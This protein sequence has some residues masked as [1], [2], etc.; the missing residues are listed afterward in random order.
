[1]QT[2][3]GSPLRTSSTVML[4]TLD[5]RVAQ[6]PR[7]VRRAMTRRLVLVLCLYE[8]NPGQSA[9]SIADWRHTPQG[10][11]KQRR[12]VNLDDQPG[13]EDDEMHTL[14]RISND[15]R[16]IMAIRRMPTMHKPS[17]LMKE[18]RLE[19]QREQMAGEVRTR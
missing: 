7:K 16:G 2:Q 13:S 3:P 18:K 6:L 11:Q 15:R 12:E 14:T 1:M 10:K 19:S 5:M 8:Y 4:T 9:R 17:E